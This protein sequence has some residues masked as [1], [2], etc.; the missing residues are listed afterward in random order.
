MKV[1]ELVDITNEV[2]DILHGYGIVVDHDIL[3]HHLFKAIK[4]SYPNDNIELELSDLRTIL[5]LRAFPE[6]V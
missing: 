2:D 5:E 1:D 6:I 4:E 3:A